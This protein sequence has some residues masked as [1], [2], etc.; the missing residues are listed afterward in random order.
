MVGDLDHVVDLLADLR[1]VAHQVDPATGVPERTVIAGE[2]I[3]VDALSPWLLSYKWCSRIL[4]I[5]PGR[6]VAACTAAL[7]RRS[8]SDT[9]PITWS[10][11]STTGTAL[12]CSRDSFRTISRKGMS[13]GAETAGTLITSRTCGAT[14]A[15]LP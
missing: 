11:A 13:P 8:D 6:G 12:R 15:G 10:S 5:G 4:R 1:V 9:T 14:A 2:V 7:A 3:R